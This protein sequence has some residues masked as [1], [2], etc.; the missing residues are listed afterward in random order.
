LS[1]L[2]EDAFGKPFA[3]P[4]C[5]WK[6]G[7]IKKAPNG[8][9][10]IPPKPAS[11]YCSSS[12]VLP[13]QVSNLIPSLNDECI[14]LP[15]DNDCFFSG[16]AEDDVVANSATKHEMARPLRCAEQYAAAGGKA[17]GPGGDDE[18]RSRE[19]FARPANMA[20]HSTP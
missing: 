13:S 3:T 17:L 2:E 1:F 18:F 6:V 5:I 11:Q 15:V 19:I 8:V 10:R 20:K 12:R 7:D 16:T 14:S 9:A 4:R